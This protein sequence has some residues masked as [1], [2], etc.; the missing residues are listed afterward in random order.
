MVCTATISEKG[1]RDAATEYVNR[2]RSMSTGAP[3][4]PPPSNRHSAGSSSE[5]FRRRNVPASQASYNSSLCN[6]YERP[7]PGECR[8]GSGSCFRCGKVGH[9]IRDCPQAIATRSQGSQA[10]NN[11]PRQLAQA[12][13]YAL[14]L[15]NAEADVNATDVVTGTIPLFGIIA[16]VN[17]NCTRKCKN[18]LQ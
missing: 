13:V 16:D 10:S 6:K 4:P 8:L 2:K 18:R 11:Q 15:G 12:R 14:T 17:F 3:P 5:S 7:H 9:F 1:I